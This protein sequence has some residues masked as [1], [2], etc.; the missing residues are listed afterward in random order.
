MRTNASEHT[1]HRKET[2]E[3]F[4]HTL[5]SNATQVTAGLRLT[6][7]SK[8]TLCAAQKAVDGGNATLLS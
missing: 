7:R 1:F 8:R 4:A 5:L 3:N 6:A 2:A